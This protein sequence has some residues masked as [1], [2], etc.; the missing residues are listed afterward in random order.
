MLKTKSAS[1]EDDLFPE[2]FS[3]YS[4][5]TEATTTDF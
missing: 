1:A 4:N 5:K 2:N 3:D